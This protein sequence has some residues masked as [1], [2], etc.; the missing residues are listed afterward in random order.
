MKVE[1]VFGI[2]AE[3]IMEAREILKRMLCVEGELREGADC[4]G[5]Y[6]SFVADDNSYI[7]VCKNEDLYDGEPLYQEAEGW[8]VILHVGF[9]GEDAEWLRLLRSD[10]KHLTEVF[11]DI[12]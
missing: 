6:Y 9:S 10:V 11:A 12:H 2:K 1:G 5:E 8:K 3:N 4:G 7:D